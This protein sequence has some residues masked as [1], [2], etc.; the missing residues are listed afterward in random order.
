M[1]FSYLVVLDYPTDVYCD[2]GQFELLFKQAP[3]LESVIDKSLDLSITG[4]AIKK[5][6]VVSQMSSQGLVSQHL[7]FVHF[8]N[9]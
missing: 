8:Q 3:F 9:S 4:N 7:Y 6:R 1:I 2:T 5:T